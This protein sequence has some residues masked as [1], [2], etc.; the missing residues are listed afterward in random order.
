[1]PNI[2]NT[3]KYKIL[4]T[5]I[6]GFLLMF[7]S[8]HALTTVNFNTENTDIY[9]GNTFSVDFKISSDKSI[10]VI[11]GTLVYDKTKLF[12]KDVNTDGSIFSI[13]QKSPIFDNKKGT[14][15]FVGGVPGGFTGNDGQV[16]TITFI[17]KNDGQTTIDFQDVFSVYLNDGLGTKVNPWLEPIQLTII[18]SQTE[19]TIR[20][21]AQILI[22]KDKE[23][24]HLPI[25]VLIL[26]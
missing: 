4:I 13:W 6:S 9:K 8:V 12:I 17:T 20:Q 5:A 25:I 21:I 26:L 3:I 11:D 2:K 10:N 15:T 22:K 16:L 23:Y 1:M 14:I 19:T 24:S 7:S 18:P